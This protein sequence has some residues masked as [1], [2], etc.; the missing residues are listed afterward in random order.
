MSEA[1]TEPRNSE[2]LIRRRRWRNYALAGA[3]AAF[4]VIVYFVSIVRMGGE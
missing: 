1:M 4:V 3:L 2:E